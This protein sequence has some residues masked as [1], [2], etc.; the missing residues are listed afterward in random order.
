MCLRTFVLACPIIVEQ[1]LEV[2]LLQLQPQRTQGEC[3][4]PLM[5]WKHQCLQ[6]VYYMY[7]CVPY[8]VGGVSGHGDCCL[9]EALDAS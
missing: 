1:H 3:P 7:E 2:L 9:V 5:S 4:S 8:P 6:G